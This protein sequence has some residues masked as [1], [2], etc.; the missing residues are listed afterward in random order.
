ME[1]INRRTPIVLVWLAVLSALLLGQLLSFQFRLNPSIEQFEESASQ[2]GVYTERINPHRGQ[3]Y[4]RD[5][6]VLAV[7]SFEY[8]V[9]VSPSL[10]IDRREAATQLAAVLGLNEA[11]IYRQLLPDSTGVYAPF[12]LLSERPIDDATARAVED[13]DINGVSIEPIPLRSYPQDYLTSQVVGFVNYSEEG[14]FGIEGQYDRMLAGTAREIESSGTIYELSERPEASDGQ[15]LVLTIDRDIQFVVNE[16]LA[17]AIQTYSAES[18][19]IIVMN[20]RTGEIL[21]MQSWPPFSTDEVP[22]LSGQEGFIYN[23]AIGYTFEPGS[24]MK[25]VTASIALQVDEPGLDLNW[26]YNNTGCFEAAGVSICDSDRVAKGNVAFTDCIVKSLNTCTA[27]WYSL[28]GPSK[29]Y[30]LLQDFGFGK[31]TGVDLEGEEGGIVNLPSGP[32]WSEADFLNVSYGQGISVTALQ[33]LNA[34]NAIANDGLMMQPHIVKV[35]YDGQYRFETQPNPIGRPISTEVANAIT[36]IMIK[37]VQAGEFDER[38]AIDGYTI[39]GKTGTAQQPTPAGYSITDSWASFV[40]FLPA[41]DPIISAI[42]VLDRPDQYWG[43]LT[44]APTF[45]LLMERLVVLMEIPPDE[46]RLQLN[47]VGGDPFSRDYVR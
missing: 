34:V 11:E 26:T 30:P 6:V 17:D 39:A 43:S 40:G 3:I 28:I 25:V 15:N 44:A 20:P 46:I 16:V 23:P 8:R 4:D 35:R 33:M 13:L 14:F 19:T 12:V 1:I 21:G 10:V 37:T 27:T 24:I 18:G 45:N 9:G 47:Q 42:V 41:D 2:R 36:D 32:R 22:Q 31:P 29:V 7:N 5:M 38:A